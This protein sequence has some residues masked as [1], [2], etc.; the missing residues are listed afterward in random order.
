MIEGTVRTFR[1]I[2]HLVLAHSL[3]CL[4]FE[5][6]FEFWG[7]T[8]EVDCKRC[9]DESASENGEEFGE[10][11]FDGSKVVCRCCVAVVHCS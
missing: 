8:E 1:D 9:N 4:T 3:E 11:H 5:F 2:R 6:T 7:N 10:R